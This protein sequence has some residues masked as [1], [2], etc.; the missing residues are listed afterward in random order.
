MNKFLSNSMVLKSFKKVTHNTLSRYISNV[1]PVINLSNNDLE[2][3][4]IHR[5]ITVNSYSEKIYNRDD[6]P[7]NVCVKYCENKK[8]SVIGYGPQGRGQSLNM[9]DGGFDVILGLRPEGNS[10]NKAISDG[11]VPNVNLFDIDEASKQSQIIQ[12]L[13]S[14]A[15]QIEYWPTIYK[16]L[17]DNDTLYFSHGF[18]LVYN[19]QTNIIPPKNIDIILVAPKGPGFMLRDKFIN[20]SGINC[21]F[22]VHQNYSGNAYH[23]VKSLGFGIGGKNLFETTFEK[24]VY[25]DLTGERCVLMGLIQGAFKAQYD[26]LIENGHSPSE[27]FNETVEEALVSLY[28][29]INEKGMDWMFENC[30]TTAQRGALDWSRKFY[31]ILRPEIEKCYTSVLDGSETETVIKANQDKNYRENLEQ[32]LNEIKNQEIWKIGHLLRELR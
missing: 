29:M 17:E 10:W 4:N 15:G 8:I 21:S 31:D 22:A 32:E 19:N 27:A 24:E 12:Y 1:K 6:Y 11:W 13:L 7:Y 5:N 25:S 23:T 9:M 2:N 20:G 30:S 26:V 18:G 28:P 16:N 3:I 14:D